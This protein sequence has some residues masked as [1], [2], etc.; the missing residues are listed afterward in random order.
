MDILSQGGF[1]KMKEIVTD[2]WLKPRTWV[3]NGWSIGYRYVHRPR[4]FKCII[5]IYISPHHLRFDR[6]V[7][8][9]RGRDDLYALLV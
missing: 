7:Q 2:I 8:L 3:S 4:L 9:A 6:C 1:E 5:Y